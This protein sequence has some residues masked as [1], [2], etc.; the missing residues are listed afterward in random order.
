MCT[1]VIVL[2]ILVCITLFFLATTRPIESYAMPGSS[3][4]FPFPVGLYQGAIRQSS[5]RH[6]YGTF[7]HPYSYGLYPNS[8][9]VNSRVSYRN[10]TFEPPG[11]V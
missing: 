8:G 2:F 5:Q 3:E 10:N 4:R 1:L 9:Y 6:Q 7:G 11:V